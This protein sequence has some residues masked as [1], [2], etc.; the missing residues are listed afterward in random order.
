MDSQ[1]QQQQQ[2][3]PASKTG[4]SHPPS[5]STNSDRDM[6]PPIFRPPVNRA[7][8]VLDRSFFR[9]TIPLSAATVFENSNIS[10]VRSELAKSH[11][12]LTLPRLNIIRPA[13]ASAPAGQPAEGKKSSD[14]TRKCL[15]LREGIKH[16]DATTWSPTINEL[17]EKGTVG[18]G[19][20]DLELD[21]DYWSYYDIISSVLPEDELEGETPVGFTQT[22]HVL[23]LN[24]R[25]RYLPYKYLIAEILKDKNPKI[26]TVIN[27]TEDV[28]SHSEFRTFPFEVLAGDNDLN[29]VVHE[30]DCEFRFD[31]SRVYWNSRLETE[32][33][34]LV[35]KFEAGQMVCDVMA[36]VGPFA[37][38]AGKKKIFVWAN[39]L[40]PHGWEVMEDA[41]KR[42]KVKDFVTAF[43]MDGRDFIRKS[44]RDLLES[45]PVKVTIQP[46]GRR[47]KKGDGKESVPPPAPQVY[48]RPSTVDHYVMNLPATAIEFLDAFIGLYAGKESL[49]EPHTDRKLPMI[50]VYCFSGHSDEE[51]DDHIDIC[52]R[53]SERIG[54]TITPDDTVGGS[55][56][57]ALELEIHNVRLLET[58]IRADTVVAPES[59]GRTPNGGHLTWPDQQ[60]PAQLSE[61]E[62]R[63]TTSR[64]PPQARRPPVRPRSDL[65]AEARRGPEHA[66]AVAVRSAARHQQGAGE[67]AAGREEIR[68]VG[69]LDYLEVFSRFKDEENI[70]AV[71]R[72]LNSH[73]ELEMFERSQL[74]S[75]CCDNAEE[76]KSL[77]PSLQNKISDADLQ[78]LLDELTKLRNFGE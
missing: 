13:P 37:V 44:A 8:R 55:G 38:P 62:Q 69:T 72:L 2:Q 29:V 46:K 36:G 73:T 54:Y 39:D 53:I 14:S 3:P 12:L 66:H 31:F 27:K 42:N 25:E 28:G 17:V 18:L 40:N 32:H 49:F 5:S 22:G 43:N 41:I 7:M 50:H 60:A 15:I 10:R 6:L 16:D 58:S 74:G 19:P 26:R 23:H 68:G 20:Y 77:I 48:V 65:V 63:A 24:L 59:A 61:D 35:E 1:Q 4:A 52:K 70:K 21:Y 34:R 56:N 51:R 47:D 30:Q 75:L 64:H 76:A 9:K 57:P 71:E 33:R 45:E 11:D 67:Q 78:E